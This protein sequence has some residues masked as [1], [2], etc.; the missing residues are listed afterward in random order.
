MKKIEILSGDIDAGKWEIDDDG[1][2]KGKYVVKFVLFHEFVSLEKVEE[3]GRKIHITASLGSGQKFNAVMSR[4]AYNTLYTNFVRKGNKPTG[5][6]LPLSKF[7]MLEVSILAV[8]VIF[9]GA[10]AVS[11]MFGEDQGGSGEPANGLGQRVS[12]NQAY[13]MEK[14]P[15]KDKVVLCKKYIGYIFSRPTDIISH[16]RTDDAGLI[17]V[18]YIRQNDNT[19]WKNVCD[20]NSRDIV[21][22]GWMKGAGEWGRWREEDRSQLVY[23]SDENAV[24]FTVPMYE[25]K[26]VVPLSQ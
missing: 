7:S 4:S 8:V 21:W 15:E 12:K 19:L 10:T 26:L 13:D 17:Y 23:N 14:L 11:S 1:I 3:A 18:S 25:E 24:E 22:A 6:A 5:T 20:V 2:K 9:V 16:D